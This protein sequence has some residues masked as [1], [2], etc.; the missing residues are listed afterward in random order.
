MPA[1]H[2]ARC[3]PER[4]V[5]TTLGTPD[6]PRGFGTPPRLGWAR[7]SQGVVGLPT[8]RHSVRDS[9]SMDETPCHHAMRLA[10][11]CLMLLSLSLAT[12]ATP[13]AQVTGTIT[14]LEPA[15][16]TVVIEFAQG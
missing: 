8:L 12:A 2:Q 1:A 11:A 5:E 6:A 7:H 10:V 13:L 4:V 16:Q 3:V 15:A 9:V 14:A